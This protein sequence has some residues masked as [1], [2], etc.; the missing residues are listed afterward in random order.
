MQRVPSSGGLQG[1]SIEGT[2][3]SLPLYLI[4][5]YLLFTSH[6]LYLKSA[7]VTPGLVILLFF[8]SKCCK[9]RIEEN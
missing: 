2:I 1:F 9:C 7:K 8:S 4:P 3:N 6:S 5:L